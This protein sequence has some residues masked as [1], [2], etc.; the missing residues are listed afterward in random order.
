MKK[1]AIPTKNDRVDSHFGH[2]EQFS[3]YSADQTGITKNEIIE[4]GE[5]CGCRSNII[6]VLRNKGVTV[7]LAGNMGEGA[8]QRLVSEGMEVI[9]GCRGKIDTLVAAYA[10]GKLYDDGSNCRSHEH[11][12]HGHGVE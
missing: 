3:I 4:S 8:Y 2:A 7:M 10:S 1:I 5:G 12:H 11:H 6:Q 9:R